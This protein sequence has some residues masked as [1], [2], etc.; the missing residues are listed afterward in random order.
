MP[1]PNLDQRRARPPAVALLA[2]RH[3]AAIPAGAWRVLDPAIWQQLLPGGLLTAAECREL[4]GMAR[5]R[6]LAPA[7]VI[8]SRAQPS[9][10]LVAL[11]EGEASLGVRSADGLFRTERSVDG[12]AWL[13][14]S[15]A[16]IGVAHSVDAQATSAARIVDLPRS[17]LMDC[18]QRH[19]D[20][21]S[22]LIE[23]L[24]R[25]VHALAFNNHELMH[26]DAPARLAHW[27]RQRCQPVP[28][29][30]GQALVQLR[31]RKRD[32]ASQLAITPETLSRL[33]RSMAQQGL[34]R[35]AGYTV[36]VLDLPA[37][38][39]LLRD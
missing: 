1:T 23:N 16:F 5:V 27:L 10:S 4:D 19:P 24:A 11:A 15:S 38:E 6:Q 7:E 21:A 8:F 34:I 26:K 32:V 31:E 25:E 36:Q 29:C 35:V 18:L 28:G 13:D 14:V 20:L 39:Q 37:L 9:F 17:L 30:A 2:E 33:L 12:P 3:V 22:R